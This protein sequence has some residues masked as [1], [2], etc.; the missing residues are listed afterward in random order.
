[1]Q[2]SLAV[3]DAFHSDDPEH[4]KV[5]DDALTYMQRAAKK[6]LTPLSYKIGMGYA[7]AAVAAINASMKDASPAT[8]APATATTKPKRKKKQ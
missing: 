6:I 3:K 8:D 2:C 7:E 5:A 4:W 1:L